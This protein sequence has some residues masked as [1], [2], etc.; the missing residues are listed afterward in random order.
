MQ[1]KNLRD[2][3]RDA[4]R[5]QAKKKSG[6]GA[7]TVRPWVYQK[8]MEFLIPFMNNRNTSSN[9]SESQVSETTNQAENEEELDGHLDES[10]GIGNE[11]SLSEEEVQKTSE[12]TPPNK[13]NNKKMKTSDL[14]EAVMKSIT[15][16]EKRAAARDEV[17][18]TMAE[19]K[20]NEPSDPLF[21]FF[22]SMYNTTKNLPLSY[23]LQ[24]KR[25]IFETVS[26]A[27]E[28]TMMSN[29]VHGQ[30]SSSWVLTSG[31]PSSVSSGQ[32]DPSLATYWSDFGSAKNC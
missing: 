6:Q 21:H 29:M 30:S 9:L 26:E 4:L 3:F 22:M 20:G 32:E 14:N 28:N 31:P 2:C 8:Q 7:S 25:K 17:R 19:N 11:L 1:W 10:N 18:K 12:V 5:R 24:V 27:E 13:S 16:Y 23:Q 15:N